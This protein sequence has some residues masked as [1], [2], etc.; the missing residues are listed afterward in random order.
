MPSA[1]SSRT[2]PEQ[3]E[4]IT[5]ALR[6]EIS[7]EGIEMLRKRGQFGPLKDLFPIEAGGWA[8]QAG[9]GVEDCVAFKME[10]NGLRAEVVLMKPSTLNSQ[11]STAEAHFRILRCNNVK[12]MAS[13]NP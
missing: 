3:I 6:D 9:V 5:K 12:Q 10:R 11:P 4:F 13:A 8:K 1:I 2:V 7:P